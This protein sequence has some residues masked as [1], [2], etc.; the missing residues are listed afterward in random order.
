MN[1]NARKSLVSVLII[2]PK[3][4]LLADSIH[5]DWAITMAALVSEDPED[6]AAATRVWPRYRTPAVC[7][8]ASEIP[9][10]TVELADA[11]ESLTNAPAWVVIDFR[12]KRLLYG[13]D[14]LPLEPDSFIN[15]NP[16]E[17]SNDNWLLVIHLPPWW[18]LHADGYIGSI[19]Q[20]RESEISKRVVNRDILYGTPLLRDLAT[21]LVEADG[22]HDWMS[23]TAKGF[24]EKQQQLIIQIHRDWLMTPREDL[25]GRIPREL[26]HGSVSWI[27]KLIEGQRHRFH[28]G[29]PF[30]GLP[31]DWD[32]SETGPIG[33]AEMCM[34][35]TLC[36]TLVTTGWAVLNEVREEQ[37][38]LARDE[39]ITL[40]I[41]DLESIKN[42]WMD[43]NYEDDV[44]PKIVIEYERRRVPRGQGLVIDGFDEP[45]A[46][47]NTDCDCPICD[48]MNEGLFGVGFISYDGYH[49]EMDNE[50][51]FS[52]YETHEEWESERQAYE[53]EYGSDDYIASEDWQGNDLDGEMDDEVD[54]DLDDDL[55]PVWS[56]I[57][58]RDEMPGGQLPGDSSGQLLMAF[59]LSEL[60]GNLQGKNAPQLEIDALNKEFKA[61]RK[62][63]GK[64]RMQLAA[65]FKSKLEELTNQYPALTPKIA[66]F[67]SMID[68]SV[69]NS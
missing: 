62:S 11:I 30:T 32:P 41:A 34:Y 66:D 20:S 65:A 24:D 3:K 68:E 45:G 10:E 40:L 42:G 14:I 26:L 53:N 5:E 15:T 33:R 2:D 21:R 63:S 12:S 1:D 17:E 29:I 7:Q 44:A 16:D 54:D 22:E 13:G 51:A 56:G 46:T 9:L 64:E 69:R 39:K 18:E 55:K 8:D 60:T 4:C 23:Y 59:M 67:Q 19:P 28:S 25:G 6:W 61:M 52:I 47:H 50:F 57:Q 43:S 27:E 37:T 35:F 31:K 49:L 36:R 38:S 58:S 48:V